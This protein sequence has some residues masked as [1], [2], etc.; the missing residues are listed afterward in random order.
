MDFSESSLKLLIMPTYSPEELCFNR[1]YLRF[2]ILTGMYKQFPVQAFDTFWALVLHPHD[3][4][5][6]YTHVYSTVFNKKKKI[7]QLKLVEIPQEGFTIEGKLKKTFL[8]PAILD[9]QKPTRLN[10]VDFQS[11]RVLL[12]QAVKRETATRVCF[13]GPL[14]SLDKQVR[15]RSEMLFETRRTTC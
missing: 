8:V 14:S 10:D 15:W 12:L 13:P 11:K 5:W 6:S 2:Y 7:T 4:I 9:T 1:T 3:L